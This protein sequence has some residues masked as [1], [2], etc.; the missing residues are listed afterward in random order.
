[1][2]EENCKIDE[3]VKIGKNTII[4]FGTIIED[5]CVIGNNCV[6]GPY[7]HIHSHSI[8]SDNCIIGNFVEIKNSFLDTGC[9]AKHLVYIGDCECGK[10][11]NFGC[12]AV[13]ANYDGKTKH[14]TVIKDDAFIGCNT[15]LIAPLK[16]GENSFIAAGSTV[17]KDVENNEF[18]IERSQEVHK[19]RKSI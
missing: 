12:G 11:V 9:K 13:I 7:A 14:K 2:I 16:V 3:T 1:M 15:N 17:N 10:N 6:I 8:I 4:K 18:V 5:D 19:I